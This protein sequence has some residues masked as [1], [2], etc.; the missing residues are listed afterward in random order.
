MCGICGYLGRT[1]GSKYVLE[2]IKMLR[3]RGYDSMGCCSCIPNDKEIMV[4]KY[5]NSGKDSY[6]LL[7]G[8]FGVHEGSSNLIAHCRWATT[9]R[10]T[11][12][13][14]HPHLDT[15]YPNQIAL[16]H[17]GIISNYNDV[18]N[19]LISKGIGFR[20][21]TDTE[22]IVNLIAYYKKNGMNSTNIMMDAIKLA[23]KDLD[24]TWALVIM[25]VDEPESMYVC[26]KGSPLLV[27]YSEDMCI[28]SSELSGFS[29]YLRNYH[30][31][32]DNEIIRIHYNNVSKSIE[33]YR[34]D[35]LT[36]LS[37]QT[38]IHSTLHAS[39]PDPYPYWTIKEIREQKESVLRAINHGGRIYNE[40]EVK[41]GGLKGHRKELLAIRDLI[42]IAN[43]TSYHAGLLSQKY[44]QTIG[45]FNTVRVIDASEFT[46]NDL[47]QNNTGTNGILA[48]S[49]SGE[50]RDVVKC[51]EIVQEMRPDVM[52]FSVINTVESQ[53]A[54]ETG[55][56]IYL[57]AGR[58]MGVASTKCFTSQ[59]I[60]LM[61]LTIW[62]AQNR[63]LC[64]N[65]RSKMI[66][67]L[68]NIGELVSSTLEMMERDI[69]PI[70]EY[71]NDWS[72]VFILGRDRGLA[73]AMEAALKIKE[74]SYIHAEA[75]AAGALKHGPLA[76]ITQGT[77]VIVIRMGD[78][79]KMDIAAEET[80]VRGGYMIQI[81]SSRCPNEDLYDCEI[82]IPED[83]YMEPL[84]AI[85]PLQYLAYLL[86]VHRGF[87]PDF[88]RNLAKC[89]S[90]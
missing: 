86:S 58:E 5:A 65:V 23:L 29:N 10:V 76:L 59:V 46:L 61:L 15:I 40:T 74:I 64:E 79:E 51:L 30:S 6:E 44:M 50:T 21:E 56:G 89:V 17:N 68:H 26:K 87:N 63:N 22:V 41:L 62:Y 45:G 8:S 13:N 90:V 14:S 18:K 53:I 19:F 3:N 67:S 75:Y 72:N 16:A 70:V 38:M 36:I 33:F 66:S 60:V 88:P 77:P 12:S 85:I 69:P 48:I 83:L 25:N 47:T 1:D 20:S 73:V 71:I 80:K 39:N 37:S 52:L 27:G 49:Q 4:T 2:G 84:L 78:V 35:K 81:G 28:V 32:K 54:R 34:D 24:G 42:I 9:G 57:N 11:D 43:G 31:V 55:C 82:I 7:E